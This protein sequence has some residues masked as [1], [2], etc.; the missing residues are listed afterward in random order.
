MAKIITDRELADVV[1]RIVHDNQLDDMATYLSFLS[2]LGTLVTG[3]MGGV[4]GAA[5]M[6]E[7]EFFI[8]I[9]HDDCV[10]EDG[11]IWKDYDRDCSVEEW[12]KK[13]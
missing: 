13:S 1:R 12:S 8:P 6:D 9:R 2:E 3:F 5:T 11:G 4:S 7:A 10:P